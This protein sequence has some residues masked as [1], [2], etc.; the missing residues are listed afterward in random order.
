MSDRTVTER[1][2]NP[3]TD[4]EDGEFVIRLGFAAAICPTCNEPREAGDC[5]TCGGRIPVVEEGEFERARR[6]AFGPLAAESGDLVDSFA[7]PPPAELTLSVDQ[8]VA[9]FQD[10]DVI[11]QVGHFGK[12]GHR[13]SALDLDDPAVVG[14]AARRA[15]QDELERIR[16]LRTDLWELA[17]F[18]AAGPAM[19]LR[20]LAFD[21]GRW[22]AELV[23]KFLRALTAAK[24]SDAARIAGAVREFYEDSPFK[25]RYPA[26]LE[27]LPA[28]TQPDDDTRLA[29][30]LGREGSYTDEHGQLMPQAIVGVVAD[31]AEPFKALGRVAAAYFKAALG[32]EAVRDDEAANALLIVPAAT[33][34]TL[35]RPLHAH[36]LARLV[37]VLVS[38]AWSEDQ[39][40]VTSVLERGIEQ[41]PLIFSAARRIQTQFR[42]LAQTAETADVPDDAVVAS[43]LAAY[44]EVMETSF[45]ILGMI[46]IDLV[47]ITRGCAIS[48]SDDPPML[49]SLVHQLQADGEPVLAEFGSAADVALRNAAAHAQYRWDEK[50]RL[51]ED[52]RTGQRWREDELE[53]II[54]RVVGVLAGVD[55]AWACFVARADL[56]ISPSWLGDPAMADAAML[57]ATLAFGSH[58][59]RVTGLEE[60]G[61]I[62]VIDRPEVLDPARIIPSLAG[63][64]LIA[65]DRDRYIIKDRDGTQL[66]AVRGET[67]KR[68]ISAEPDMQDLGIQEVT[69]DALIESGRDPSDAL[70]EIVVLDA[71]VVAVSA[72]QELATGHQRD[73]ALERL[74]RRASYLQALVEESEVERREFERLV[75]KLDRITRSAS[76]A[77]ESPDNWRRLCDQLSGL[78][79]WADKR[80]VIW[81]PRLGAEPAT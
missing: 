3:E 53:Q 49:G 34:A 59:F 48:E 29:L 39:A 44:R 2:N 66:L 76:V 18:K 16:Q 45:R 63:M 28:W 42:L 10:L 74:Q 17:R 52:L 6:Q 43:L 69:L 30:L 31:E 11:D 67:I 21:T 33:M 20:E 4:P 25:E 77:T 7:D 75:D 15:I 65:P 60:G 79:G 23:D 47:T 56:E 62:V 27:Q 5:P 36:R 68:A 13:L 26:V 72:L 24:V 81:P 51:V 35:D 71:K 55:A 61:A 37:H 80:G 19:D 73:A 64:A 40:A 78:V 14:G 70:F 46:A 12:L 38:R 1:R 8:F 9:C 22:A 50:V 54:D 32:A 57:Q 58:G 41:A